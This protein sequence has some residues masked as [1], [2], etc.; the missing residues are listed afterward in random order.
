[1]KRLFSIQT[2]FV[3]AL[4]SCFMLIACTASTDDD[5]IQQRVNEELTKDR[6]GAALNATVDNGVVTVTGECAG[7]NCAEDLAGKIKKMQGVKDVQI[8]VIAKP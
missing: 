2:A 1:M 7:D 5:A 8:N 3:C 4:Y 6:A